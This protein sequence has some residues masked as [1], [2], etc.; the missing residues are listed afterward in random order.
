MS[1]SIHNPHFML[2]RLHSLL[3]LL[4]V[5]G[6]LVFHLWENSQS[7]LGAAHYN[8]EVVAA[9]QGLNYLPVLEVVLIALP[10]LFHAGYGLAV[11]RQGRAEPIR[12]PYLRNRRYWLQRLSGVGI[13]AFLLL[14][15]WLTRI[16]G[17]L[18]PALRVDLYAHMQSQ[19]SDPWVLAIYAIGLLLSVFHLAN[20]LWSMSIVWGLAVSARAQ[21]R[22]AVACAGIGV[23]LAALGLHGL[24]GFLP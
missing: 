14:H 23:L 4:P 16:Q 11:I 24:I 5:G 1:A 21:D 20:G 2:R 13:L 8:G 19:L 7:R 17:I 3:G 15:L 9:L 6:F 12:Y 22:I 10:L 18:E